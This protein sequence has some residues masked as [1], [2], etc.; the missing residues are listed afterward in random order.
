[1]KLAFWRQPTSLRLLAA[2][3]LFLVSMDVQAT[4][5]EYFTCFDK[6]GSPGIEVLLLE[7]RNDRGLVIMMLF[8]LPSGD[9]FIFHE[10]VDAKAGMMWERLEHDSSGWWIEYG[11]DMHGTFETSTAFFD[12]IFEI[13]PPATKVD[14]YVTTFLR[15]EVSRY[16]QTYDYEPRKA[17]DI[18]EK[19]RSSALEDQVTFE[20]AQDFPKSVREGIFMLSRFDNQVKYRYQDFLD[21][22]VRLLERAGFESD[23]EQEEFVFER[24]DHE[25]GLGTMVTPEELEFTSRFESIDNAD[26]LA[27]FRPEE[28]F[29]EE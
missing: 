9:R 24:V 12:H 6:A 21:F 5:K 29:P 8:A 10:I 18:A 14:K 15:T 7:D 3:L 20:L 28:L 1:M 17:G 22:L 4:S 13:N 16:E 27:G 11:D 26:P 19:F 25:W 2:I 23:L